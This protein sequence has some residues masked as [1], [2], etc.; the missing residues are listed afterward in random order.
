[1]YYDN[2]YKFHI[3]PHLL[4]E[5][6]MRV[7]WQ[8]EEDG[9]IALSMIAIVSIVGRQN[10]FLTLIINHAAPPSPF[11]IGRLAISISSGKY[12]DACAVSWK[13]FTSNNFKNVY[14]KSKEE[15]E[16]EEAYHAFL[17]P[18]NLKCR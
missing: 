16:E 2:C 15:E 3:W 4:Q 18:V 8:E 13:S 5:I 6:R 7:H 10:A 1:M 9:D 11:P 14:E 12:T 17:C